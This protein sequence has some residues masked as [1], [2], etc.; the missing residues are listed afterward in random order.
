M[1]VRGFWQIWYLVLILTFCIPGCTSPLITATIN[2]NLAEMTRLLDSGEPVDTRD[3]QG[4]TSLY[5]AAQKGRPDEVKLLLDRGAD[6]NAVT[7]EDETPLHVAVKVHGNTTVRLL[8]DRGANVNAKRK[9]GWTPLHLAASIDDFSNVSL[10]LAHG[11]DPNAASVK[12]L[13]KAGSLDWWLPAGTTPLHCAVRQSPQTVVALA[14]AGAKLDAQDKDGNTPLIV[15]AHFKRVT[16]V[17]VLLCYGSDRNVRNIKGEDAAMAAR[18]REP[19]MGSRWDETVKQTSSIIA[20]FVSEPLFIPPE[21]ATQD[22]GKLAHIDWIEGV[23]PGELLHIDGVSTA[24]RLPHA[25]VQPGSH[26]FEYTKYFSSSARYIDPETGRTRSEK[27]TWLDSE[28]L[29]FECNSGVTYRWK[30]IV[31]KID[32]DALVNPSSNK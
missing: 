22:R 20:A 1:M 21:L 5:L 12:W 15:A 14:R 19:Y 11:A 4:A 18:V 16:A 17:Y 24:N 23:S 29:K 13:E 2:G 28:T 30:D 31:T 25:Y 27:E 9:D 3:P 7:A 10:L 6:V 8:L 32:P 26:I